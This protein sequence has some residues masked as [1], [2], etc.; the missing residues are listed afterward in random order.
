MGGASTGAS[1]GRRNL[2]VGYRGVAGPGGREGG[3]REEGVPVPTQARAGRQ[4]RAP[5][6]V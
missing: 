2:P 6:Q 4:L 1:S 5:L 3:D